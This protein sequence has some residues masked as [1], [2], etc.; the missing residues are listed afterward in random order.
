MLV[1]ARRAVKFVDK[2]TPRQPD[3]RS[4]IKVRQAAH[5]AIYAGF[6]TEGTVITRLNYAILPAL[7]NMS[8][9]I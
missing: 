6:R 2:P 4:L 9:R 5:K 8:D 1:E 3:I 7:G